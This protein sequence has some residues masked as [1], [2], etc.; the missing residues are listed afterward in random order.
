M[1]SE[2]F[3]KNPNGATIKDK[4]IFNENPFTT[5]KALS[6]D[7]FLGLQ[8]ETFILPL[9]L[10]NYINQSFVVNP[11]ALELNIIYAFYTTPFAHY[12]VGK[13]L[14]DQCQTQIKNLL[15]N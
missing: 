1:Q 12:F 9:R 5:S 14:Q 7:H 11:H 3:V 8:L 2:P 4:F 15:L 10:L 13:L 6:S